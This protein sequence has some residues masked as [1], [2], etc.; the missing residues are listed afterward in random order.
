MQQL[1]TK[2][3]GKFLEQYDV[4]PI[5]S[6]KAFHIHCLHRT[7]RIGDEI[8]WK[9]VFGKI[10]FIKGKILINPEIHQKT[11]VKNSIMFC[12]KML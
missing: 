8:P 7:P 12:N 1:Y 3:K 9:F 4:I 10:K 11:K 6:L 5:E 2:T